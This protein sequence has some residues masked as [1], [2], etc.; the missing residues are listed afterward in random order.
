MYDKVYWKYWSQCSHI[1]SI[2]LSLQ[3]WKYTCSKQNRLKTSAALNHSVLHAQ[4]CR[5]WGLYHS[6]W[7]ST[8]TVNS[9]GGW[10]CNIYRSLDYRFLFSADFLLELSCIC[11]QEAK[12]DHSTHASMAS[13]FH[14]NI[15]YNNGRLLCGFGDQERNSLYV[16]RSFAIHCMILWWKEDSSNL[17]LRDK[18]VFKL[19]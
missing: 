1:I 2:F 17:R 19:T 12:D 3:E 10:L 16:P 11:P 7:I 15:N 4:D 8:S 13:S 5:W 14:L 9:Y 18:F 6:C